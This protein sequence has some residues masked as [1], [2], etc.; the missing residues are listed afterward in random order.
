MKK[1]FVVLLTTVLVV[2]LSACKPSNPIE[3]DRSESA[4]VI[5][6]GA[7]AAGLSA[8]L[9]AIEHGA[10]KVIILE[11]L[12]RTGGALNTTSGT[13][14][15]AETIIQ[16]LDGLTEDSLELYK[17]D[18]IEE[19]SKHGGTPNEELVDVFVKETKYAVNWLWEKGLNDYNF[20][21]DSKGRKSVFAPEHTLYSYPRSY[22][23]I[24]K[25]RQKYRSAVHEV[26]DQLI[27]NEDKIEV[28]FLVKAERLIA[29]K[30]GQVVS[31]LATDIKTNEIVKYDST[32]GVIMATG[33]YAGNQKL[34]GRFNEHGDVFITGGLATADGLGLRIMQEVGGA[35][36][37]EAMGWIPTYPLGLESLDYPGTGRIATTKTQFAGGILVNKEGLRFVDETTK[38]VVKREVALERQPGGVQFEIYTDKIVQDLIAAGQGAFMQ[39]FFLTEAFAPYVTKANSLEEL[40]TKL[41]IPVDEFIQTVNSYNDAVDSESDDEFGRKFDEVSQPFNVAINKIEGETFYAVATRPLVLLTLGGI[42]ANEKMQ[43]LDESNTIIPGLY[44]AGEVVGGVWGRYISSGTGVMGPISFGRLAGRMVMQEEMAKNY[45]VSEASNIIPIEYFEKNPLEKIDLYDMTGVK[46]GKYEATVD[47]QNG[48]MT[49]QVTIENGQIDSVVVVSNNETESFAKQAFDIMLDQFVQL[50]TPDIDVV[51]GATYT[52]ERLINAVKLCLDQAKE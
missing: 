36:T 22:K 10:E 50:N 47:G 7:G 11:M 17:K 41:D 25:D 44:A 43:V 40:A 24:A 35:L 1:I 4:E 9:S 42:Q 39:F 6:V 21:T 46:D 2:S 3:Y 14:S 18:I 29:N 28:H 30:N 20:A 8:A 51:S 52:S 26:L 38:D 34:M 27:E 48:P 23:P 5:V 45:K 12:P 15:G 32:R 13:I 33:G 31:V 16:E 37:L 49:V 19:G